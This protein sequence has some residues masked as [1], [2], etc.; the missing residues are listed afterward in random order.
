MMMMMMILPCLLVG[1]HIP[2]GFFDDHDHDYDD[3]QEEEE[4]DDDDH[5]LPIG[6]Q[7]HS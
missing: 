4:E 1:N 2:K 5:P 7:P 3:D 6:G